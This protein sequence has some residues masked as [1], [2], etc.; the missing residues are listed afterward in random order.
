MDNPFDF[1]HYWERVGH[2]IL[3]FFDNGITLSHRNKTVYYRS[4]KTFCVYFNYPQR[5]KDLFNLFFAIGDREELR[6]F[7]PIGYHVP[8]MYNAMHIPY[9]PFTMCS[10][11]KIREKYTNLGYVTSIR[12][13]DSVINDYI[14]SD[15]FMRP[16]EKEGKNTLHFVC[17]ENLAIYEKLDQF[18][19][20]TIQSRYS[21]LLLNSI[22]GKYSKEELDV[23][24]RRRKVLVKKARTI[25]EWARKVV[26]TR[27]LNE[28]KKKM[29]TFVLVDHA[30]S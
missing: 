6:K 3:D 1:F 29:L 26:L 19:Y 4:S 13:I 28:E 12:G 16:N 8:R 9:G 2:L 20:I 10:I 22:D 25:Q 17:S 30:K 7:L 18:Y 15:N 14:Q 5:M 21:P 23:L 11:H 24:V 27:Y